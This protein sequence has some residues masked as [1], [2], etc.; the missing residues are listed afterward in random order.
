MTARG[1][2]PPTLTTLALRA[3]R[4]VLGADRAIVVAV[5]GGPDSQALLDVLARLRP[6]LQLDLRAHGVDHGL[7]P[8]AA[9]E[10]DRAAALADALEVPFSRTRLRVADGGNLQARAREARYAALRT[11]AGGALVATAHHADDRA[12]TVLIRLLRGGGTSALGVLPA[13]SGQLIRPLIR[14]RRSDVLLHLE[15]HEIGYATDPSNVDPRFLRTRVR[16]EVLPLL[17]QLDPR[18]VEHL[19]ALADEVAASETEDA[20]PALALPRPTRDALAHLL[21]QAQ[22]APQRAAKAQI[23][24]PGGLVLSVATPHGKKEHR[25][26]KRHKERG[27]G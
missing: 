20:G 24:L 5:S 12:E 6:K 25:K 22:T 17:A 15:R 2:H 9:R 8:G 18:I 26:S 4:D 1:S 27:E 7:R 3:L 16:S 23:L 19:G 11:V 21:V 10:L 13:R 14:A